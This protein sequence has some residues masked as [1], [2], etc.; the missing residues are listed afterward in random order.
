MHFKCKKN[1][2]NYIIITVL[3]SNNKDKNLKTGKNACHIQRKKDKGDI[4]FLIGNDTSKGEWSNNVYNAPKEEK[5]TSNLEFQ[6][7]LTGIGDT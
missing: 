7:F 3:K 5:I 1:K 6:Q 4:S 2:E